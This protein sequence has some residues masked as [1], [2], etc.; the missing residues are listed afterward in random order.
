MTIHEAIFSPL[1]QPMLG[2]LYLLLTAQ[3]ALFL[4]SVRDGRRLRVRLCLLMQF[5]LTFACLWFPLLDIDSNHM[6]PDGSAPFPFPEARSAVTLLPFW[7]LF[8]YE[9]LT[10]V[11]VAAAVFDMLRYRENHPT[12]ESV[13]ETMDNLPVGIAFGEADGTVVFHNL[14]MSELSRAL[15][16]KDIHDWRR[17]RDALPEGEEED[18]DDVREVPLP[19]SSAVWQISF[20]TAEVGKESFVRLT[21][22]DITEEAAVTR[23]LEEKNRKLR[24]LQTRMKL[25]NMQA[26]KIITAQELLTARMAVHR[27]TGSILLEC[28]HYL[29]DPASYDEEKLLAALKNTN[30]YLLR[31][32]EQDD[33]E[34]DP[35]TD[36]FERARAIGVDVTLTG[37]IPPDGPHRRILAAAIGECA[38]NTVKHAD[39]DRVS[40]ELSTSD[41]GFVYTLRSGSGP[42]PGE[43]RESGGLQTLRMLVE[44]NCGAMQTK[45]FPCFT[46][47]IR[48]PRRI[49]EHRFGTDT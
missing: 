30:T 46:L 38:T 2:I 3:M 7:A 41:D 42:V 44:Q 1:R 15:T 13:K 27:E 4:L 11:L 10:A 28:R 34:R 24:E 47:T 21:A 16:D 43:I 25:Y 39:G 35:L 17:F 22:T 26:D 23:E 48:L 8:L 5:L 45:G 29:K 33:T 18:G 19:D 40:A 31:E 9:A 12:A 36:T 20:D 32:Y 14:S 6:Q 37:P 49:K